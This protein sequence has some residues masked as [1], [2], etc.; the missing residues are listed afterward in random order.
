MNNAKLDPRLLTL[1]N[2]SETN[3]PPEPARGQG[4]RPMA[5]AGPARLRVRRTGVRRARVAPAAP[6]PVLTRVFLECAPSA[7]LE[8]A[9]AD[10]SVSKVVEGLWTATIPLDHVERVVGNRAVRRATLARRL[11]PLLDKALP[12][13]HIPQFRTR[14][15][16]TGASVVVGVIDTGIDGT[17]EAFQG[18]ILRVWDQT[19]RGTGVPE[20]RYGIELSGTGLSRSRD[21]NGHG[22]HVAGIAAGSHGTFGGVAPGASIVGVRTTMDDTDIAD[23]VR[24]IFRIARERNAPAVINLSIGGHDDGH[25]GSD[26]L[27]RVIDESS[28]PGRIVCCAAGNEGDDNIHGVTRATRGVEV[29]MRLHVPGSSVTEASLTGW[30]SPSSRLEIAVRTPEGK[31]TPFQGVIGGGGRPTRTY[32][33]SGTDIIVTTP[34]P[35][36]AN[37]D[38]NFRVTLRSDQ[39]GQKVRQGIWQLRLRLAS[40][41]AATVH[42]WTLDDADSPEVTFTGTSRS[43]TMKVGSPGS[44]RRAITVASFTTKT[45]WIDQDGDQVELAHAPGKITSFS[46]EGPLRNRARKPD[47]TAPGAGIA[48]AFSHLSD[49]DVED[50]I[51]DQITVLSGTSMASPFVAG[52]VALMLE[53]EPR[54]SPEQVKRRLKAASRIPGRAAGTFDTK[55]GYGLVDADR[56]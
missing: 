18:R 55:W 7:T 19:R 48:S 38:H 35:D 3:N 20:G 26:L 43:D 52:L 56:L 45:R 16:L 47:V 37:G 41:P 36:P 53:G 15:G 29:G 28:G 11:R 4:L 27:C 10:A 8:F 31:V 40:G 51:D 50:I 22:T 25:D 32:T 17:L 9:R 34:G 23:A 1:L 14:L 54:L 33:L 13:V 44:A 12:K 42:V 24:Y 30:Y 5:M 39:R 6:P 2:S 21:T 49:P 46:S